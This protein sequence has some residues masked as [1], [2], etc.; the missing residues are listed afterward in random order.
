MSIVEQSRVFCLFFVI[1][2]IIGFW[3]DIFRSIRKSLR[4]S[5][6]IVCFQDIFF[7]LICGLIIFRGV[8]VINDGN[9]RFYIGIAIF[10][11]IIIYS[12]TL[13]NTCVII[14]TIFFNLIKKFLKLIWKIFSFPIDLIK[15]I[16]LKI[17]CKFVFKKKNE[18]KEEVS[19]NKN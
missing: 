11:G 13:S 18:N 17:K 7:L 10:L 3:F 9:L 2:L 5:D 12:L 6:I 8:I 14:M 1:G 16:N 4:F 19:E 15:N